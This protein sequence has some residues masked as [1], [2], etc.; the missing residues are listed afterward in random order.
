MSPRICA[1]S[2]L[3]LA[4]GG[5]PG[6]QAA[7]PGYAEYA[8]WSDW[9]RLRMGVRPGLASSYDRSGANDD[10]NH[11]EW[12]EGLIEDDHP[13]IVK[14]IAGP[15]VIYRFWMPHRTAN[16]HFE[17]R[18]YF[19]GEPTPR[20]DT[21]SDVLFGGTYSY[22]A[23]PLVDTC[24]GGQ[25]CY[26]PIPF[27]ES[28]RI[29]TANQAANRHYYQYTYLTFPSGTPL[30]SYSGTLTPEQQA[31]RA[32]VVTMFNNVGQHPAGDS[33]SAVRLTTPASV[34]PAGESLILAGVGGAGTVRQLSVRM[35]AATD[36]ELSGLHLRVTYDDDTAPA[37]DVPVAEFFGA[38]Y[39]RA[40]YRSLPI[41]TDSPDGFYCYWPMPF[42]YSVSVE[43]HNTT[44]ASIAIDSGVLEYEPGPLAVEMCYLHAL[45]MS[46]VRADGQIYH[47]IL[48]TAG[49]GH[50]VGSLLYVD[51]DSYSFSMLEGDEVIVVN[52]VITL[53]GTGLEDAFNGGYYYN[54]VAV[55][56]DE[57]EDPYPQSATRPLSGI[58][59]VHREDGVAYARADQYRWQIADRVPFSSSIDVQIEN[60]YAVVGSRWTSVALWY[61]QP[62]V[63]ADADDDGDLDLA[64]FAGL[65]RCFNDASPACVDLYDIDSDGSVD[66]ADFNEFATLMTGTW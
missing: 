9:A 17:V 43:L 25:V 57:P 37:I 48:S 62:P 56:P 46:D 32:E 29:E 65:Q 22:F 36:E 1:L 60:R 59:Y 40:A 12:P 15:G 27:A 3:L 50:Y 44:A 21:L 13:T 19:D 39:E 45:S 16:Q 5:G 20:I 6:V 64:D 34:I 42:R 55:Q 66:L 23:A 35:E 30:E 58:L 49:R 38:G 47:P 2:L 33:A 61:Q 31:A 54:W 41:G 8:A 26:E 53:N 51:Q 28:L 24:A 4:A 52:G 63:P 14:T 18:L 7:E 10:Y 11:Y